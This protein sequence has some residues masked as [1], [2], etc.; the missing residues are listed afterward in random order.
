[1][2]LSRCFVG[3]NACAQKCK[4][5]ENSNQTVFQICDNGN[6]VPWCFTV[7]RK[8]VNVKNMIFSII[9]AHFSERDIFNLLSK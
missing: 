7:L 4:Q 1:M 3:S 6:R 2:V 8:N 9:C 5:N